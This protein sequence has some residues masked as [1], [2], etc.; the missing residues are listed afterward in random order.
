ML[1]NLF[2]RPSI[3]LFY[4]FVQGRTAPYE[5][6]LLCGP[7]PTGYCLGQFQLTVLP[8]TKELLV[9]PC[10]KPIQIKCP[11]AFSELTFFSVQNPSLEVA[12]ATHDPIKKGDIVQ[13]DL[14]AMQ[15]C[16]PFAY[17]AHLNRVVAA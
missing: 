16:S 15:L 13:L 8:H 1:T 3:P 11:H 7:H 17:E 4:E 6:Y 10:I 2:F 12:A 5:A 14:L 9:E